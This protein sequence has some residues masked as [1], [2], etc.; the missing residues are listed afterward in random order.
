MKDQIQQAKRIWFTADH[1]FGH[2]NIIKYCERPFASVEEM[3]SEMISRWNEVVRLDD[4]VY[5]LGDFTLETSILK[6]AVNLN[7]YIK[8]IPG[9]HDHRWLK[10][11]M[12]IGCG[13][14]TL[15]Q[16]Y[17]IEIDAYS[18]YSAEFPLLLVLCHYA[19]RVWDRSHYGSL[20]LF[21]HSH[22]RLENTERSMDV[23]VDSH[24]FY[25]ISLEQILETLN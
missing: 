18:D 1:H 19:M 4:I 22:G 16:L 24:D 2:A 9:G 25:P 11:E 7:G 15:P 13:I 23:G 5:H 3:N 10:K 6:Y 21:G 8:I 20:H 17:L 14:E 12:N